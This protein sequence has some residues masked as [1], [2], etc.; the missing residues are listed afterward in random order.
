MSDFSSKLL[1]SFLMSAIYSFLKHLSNTQTSSGNAENKQPRFGS[2]RRDPF[3]DPSTLVRVSIQTL[4]TTGLDQLTN[5]CVKLRR[6]V[7]YFLPLLQSR[8]DN[9]LWLRFHKTINIFTLCVDWVGE[10]S[11]ICKFVRGH[12]QLSYFIVFNGIKSKHFSNALRASSLRYHLHTSTS[13][14]RVG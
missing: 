5:R 2:P 8:G 11:N 10:T 6:Q 1:I 3:F 13:R 4:G 12:V 9:W 14:S 7:A